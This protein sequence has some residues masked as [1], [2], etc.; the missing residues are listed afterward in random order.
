M[1]GA[2]DRSDT[3]PSVAEETY[4]TTHRREVVRLY[5][6]LT[7]R[8]IPS[9]IES[10]DFD[11]CDIYGPAIMGAIDGLMLDSCSFDAPPEA[12]FIEAREDRHYVGII[13]LKHVRFFG[14]RF[15]NVGIL[16]PKEMIDEFTNAS[17]EPTDSGAEPSSSGS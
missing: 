6:A 1:R 4:D 16:G 12:L 10:V 11:D 7:S 14:C 9:L 15:H 13:G 2:W 5:E 8:G 17:A 3:L